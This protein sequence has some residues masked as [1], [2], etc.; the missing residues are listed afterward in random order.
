MSNDFEAKYTIHLLREKP[1]YV[2]EVSNVFY[3]EWQDSY[4]AFGLL[5]LE[6]AIQDAE[7]N[8]IRNEKQLPLLMILLDKQSQNLIA[9]IGLEV[10]DVS[11]GNPYYNTT[12]WL[13]CTYTKPE[14]RGQGIAKYMIGKILDLAKELKYTYVWLWTRSAQG[15]FEKQGYHLVETLRHGES[16]IN[17]MRIDFDTSNY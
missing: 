6:A 16:N 15:L 14:Y 8:Y 7:M 1:E 9:T 17:V 2:Q 11:P 4:H 12:P 5:T 13:A 3:N 10:C